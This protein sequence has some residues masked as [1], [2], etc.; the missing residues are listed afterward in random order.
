MTVEDS[1]KEVEEMESK[2]EGVGMGSVALLEGVRGL[3]SL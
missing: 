2:D 1:W 3:Q